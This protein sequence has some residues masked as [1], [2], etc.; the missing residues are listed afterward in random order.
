MSLKVL[1]GLDQVRASFRMLDTGLQQRLKG[2][3]RETT[4]E[5]EAGARA[6]VH[7]SGPDSRKAKNRPGPGELRGT[8]RAEFSGEGFTGFVKAGYGK[9]RRRSRATTSRGRARA[10]RRSPAA[11]RLGNYAMVEEYGA[12]D[13]AAHPY[14]RPAREAAVPRHRA[15]LEKAINGAVQAAGGDA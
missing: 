12:H 4:L 7:V 10:R 13:R 1:S 11:Q 8:I 5:V 9:L 6:R 2:A 3:V 14:M 15:R